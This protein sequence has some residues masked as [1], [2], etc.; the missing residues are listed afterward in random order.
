MCMLKHTATFNKDYTGNLPTFFI[1]LDYD[2]VEAL[3]HE[4]AQP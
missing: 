1:A 2:L 3:S 4:S